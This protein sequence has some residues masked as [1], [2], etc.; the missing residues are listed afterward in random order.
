MKER[1][2]A[3]LGALKIVAKLRVKLL[4]RPWMPLRLP[5]SPAEAQEASVQLMRYI[6]DSR[7]GFVCEKPCI[8]YL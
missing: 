5:L 1:L 6:D 8:K 2:L 3:S 7:D 4:L